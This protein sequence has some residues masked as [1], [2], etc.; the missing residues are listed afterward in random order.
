MELIFEVIARTSGGFTAE[1]LN[2][3]IGGTK[4]ETLEELH[5]N[6]TSAVGQ[7]YGDRPAPSA[8]RIHLLFFREDLP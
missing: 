4:G 1:C 7:H 8:D 3:H 6:I 2:A 5:D